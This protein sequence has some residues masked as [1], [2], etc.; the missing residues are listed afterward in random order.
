MRWR[1]QTN[2]Q[3]ER[4][5]EELERNREA[6]VRAARVATRASIA[7]ELHD[8]VAHEVSVMVVQA[9][10]ARRGVSAAA[11]TLPPRSSRSR[12]PAARR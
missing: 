6:R 5:A 8:I 3:L 7:N 2:Q 4:Q 11:R 10:A 1:A 12:S 9:Q